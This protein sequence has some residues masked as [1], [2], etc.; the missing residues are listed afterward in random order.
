M[1]KMFYVTTSE[2]FLQM[3]Q[4]FHFTCNHLSSTCVQ[5][6][7][8]L[9]CFTRNQRKTFSKHLQKCFRGGYNV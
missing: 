3:L 7:K 5:H 9:F 6:T 1:L 8:I 4:M 2:T